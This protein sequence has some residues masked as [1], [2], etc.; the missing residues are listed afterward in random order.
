[1]N[2]QDIQL[3][4]DKLPWSYSEISGQEVHGDMLATMF[5]GQHQLMKR[6]EGIEAANGC[7]VVPPELFG[8]VDDRQVQMRIKDL[9]YRVVE[10]LSEATNTLKNKPWKN[11]FV[12]T[13]K[14][15]F[16]EELAD[17][18]H[19]FMELLITAGLDAEGIFLLYFRKHRVNQFRQ[20]SNY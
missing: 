15:H 8:E 13:D 2:T 14:D 4:L 20:D 11:S 18:L 12:A 10:E 6:Y 3:D 7:V 1:M 16:H 9:A 19:F 5:A 17:A